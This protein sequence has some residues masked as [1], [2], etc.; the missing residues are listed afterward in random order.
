MAIVHN[1]K[2]GAE[3]GDKLVGPEGVHRDESNVLKLDGK[4]K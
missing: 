2:N 1:I 3:F 4:K